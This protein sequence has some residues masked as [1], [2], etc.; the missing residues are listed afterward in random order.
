MKTNSCNFDEL[1]EWA[2][3]EVD[4]W[5]EDASISFTE[6]VCRKMEELQ[7]SRSDLAKKLDTSPAYITKILRGYSNF[8]LE[9]MVKI[10]FALDVELDISLNERVD[11]HEGLWELINRKPDER[12]KIPGL[13]SENWE[14]VGDVTL[15]IAS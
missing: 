7:I 5:V 12:R 14:V 10:A 8:T 2:Q 4:Y 11:D 13:E 6:N 3:G 9:T 15:A 1:I